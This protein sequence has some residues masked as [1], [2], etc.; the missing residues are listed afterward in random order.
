MVE[1]DD[2]GNDLVG[3]CIAVINNMTKH[4]LDRKVP[5]PIHF[6]GIPGQELGGMN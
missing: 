5:I 6:L 2:L 3:F 1:G 4:N